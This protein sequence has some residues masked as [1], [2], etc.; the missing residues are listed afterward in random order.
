M[1][2]HPPMISIPPPSAPPAS[3]SPLSNRK[4]W[5]L[6]LDLCPPKQAASL[7]SLHVVAIFFTK[8]PALPVE[9]PI[10]VLELHC[11]KFPKLLPRQ[12][13]L[14]III[15]W[16]FAIISK[17]VSARTALLDPD[18]LFFRCHVAKQI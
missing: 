12:E 3:A 17:F 14:E 6:S 10:M 7:K 15:I 8:L 5:Q 4:W 9:S 16:D 1:K 18:G 11:R 2:V 13:G